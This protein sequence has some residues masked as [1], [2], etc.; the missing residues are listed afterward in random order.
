MANGP[1]EAAAIVVM[2]TLDVTG[3]VPIQNGIVNQ[4]NIISCDT[5]ENLNSFDTLNQTI[6]DRVFTDKY[7]CAEYNQC[8][9]QNCKAFGFIP[10]TLINIYNAV[11]AIINKSV[12]DIIPLLASSI[13]KDGILT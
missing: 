5:T 7:K 8:V 11:R 6:P 4:T 3:E 10:V 13:L 2:N 1:G 12:W 9:Q